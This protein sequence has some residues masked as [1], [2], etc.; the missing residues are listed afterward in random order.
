MAR[1]ALT[2]G[3][4]VIKAMPLHL[5]MSISLSSYNVSLYTNFGIPGLSC[6]SLHCEAAVKPDLAQLSGLPVN[7]LIKVCMWELW[8]SNIFQGYTGIPGKSKEGEVRRKIIA[9]VVSPVLTI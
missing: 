7:I 2:R 3:I 9:D 4:T 6:C 5:R 1:R 8:F